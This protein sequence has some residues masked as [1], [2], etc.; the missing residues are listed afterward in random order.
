MIE[1]QIE[2]P[3]LYLVLTR[4]RTLVIFI[5]LSQFVYPRA[6]FLKILKNKINFMLDLEIRSPWRQ[7]L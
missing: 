4:K 3:Y 7:R 1:R 2:K 6:A 5:S